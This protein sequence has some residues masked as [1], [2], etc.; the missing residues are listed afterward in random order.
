MFCS[1]E[2]RYSTAK[3]EISIQKTLPRHKNLVHL[4]EGQIMKL[5]DGRKMALFLMEYCENG[6]VFDLME[7]N[8]KT[9]LKEG[10]IIKVLRQIAE[11][12]NLN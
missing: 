1:D 5:S 8:M 10:V 7:R 12:S 4:Y 9:K 6:T 11:Y 2:Q 3:R